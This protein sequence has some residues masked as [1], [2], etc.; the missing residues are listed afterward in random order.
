MQS[1]EIRSYPSHA[2]PAAEA[3]T[4]EAPT[5]ETPAAETPAE[6]ASL[7]EAPKAEAPKASERPAEE[8]APE[9]RR[10]NPEEGFLHISAAIS[11]ITQLVQMCMHAY[12]EAPTCQACLDIK[13][14]LQLQGVKSS[15]ARPG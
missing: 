11:M 15:K 5:A 6:E 7:A 1:L 2:A 9:P 3:A 13:A 10:R 4:V 14:K 8:L 12:I